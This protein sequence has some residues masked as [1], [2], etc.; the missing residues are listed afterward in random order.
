VKATREGH[1][2]DDFEGAR[3]EMERAIRR[4]GALE[5]VIL[6]CAVAL[7][8]AGGAMAAFLLTTGSSLPFRPTWAV[9]SLL[10]LGVP[11]LIVFGREARKRRREREIRDQ[12]RTGT[13]TE[14]G[15]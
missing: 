11:G 10:L 9:L 8:L 14:D 1:G 15:G 2:H 5:W 6:A 13:E 7:A 3:Q 4:L 12:A